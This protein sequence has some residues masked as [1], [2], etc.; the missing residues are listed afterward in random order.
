[1]KT[2]FLFGLVIGTVLVVIVVTLLIVFL[3]SLVVAFLT[4][5]QVVPDLGNLVRLMVYLLTI[6]NAIAIVLKFMVFINPGLD[7]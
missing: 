2:I 1:M 4:P 3:L 5:E 7:N 6:G